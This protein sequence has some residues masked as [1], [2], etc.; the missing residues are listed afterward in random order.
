MK[1]PSNDSYINVIKLINWK[2]NAYFII[3]LTMFVLNIFILHNVSNQLYWH[4]KLTVEA[5][6]CVKDP[7][8]SLDV[9]IEQ[10]YLLPDHN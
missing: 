6:A 1:N 10:D 9:L 5:M 4:D 3:L 8:C 7:D 2:I